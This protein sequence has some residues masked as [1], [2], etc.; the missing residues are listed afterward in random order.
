[1]DF[2]AAENCRLYVTTLKAMNFQDE[3]PTIP[4]DNFKDNYVLILNLPTMQD[5][6]EKFHYPELVEE[7]VRSELN[8]SFAL[9]HVT[10]LI[11]LRERVSAVAVDKYWC[12]WKKY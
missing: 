5:P 4:I 1:M 11:V 10:E 3:I 2:D 12:S 6:T 7:P 9:E 8:F